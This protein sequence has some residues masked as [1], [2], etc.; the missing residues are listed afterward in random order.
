MGFAVGKVVL[1]N[2]GGS[3]D[4]FFLAEGRGTASRDVGRL[5]VSSHC[6]AGM[7]DMA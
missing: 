1:K 2:E 4:P 3:M 6:R 5:V 7:G